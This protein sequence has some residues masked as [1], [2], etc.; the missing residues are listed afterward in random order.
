MF[1]PRRGALRPR[2]PC[3]SAARRPQLPS[4]VLHLV[5]IADSIVCFCFC[6]CFFKLLVYVEPCLVRTGSPH[7]AEEHRTLL[8]LQEGESLCEKCWQEFG[9]MQITQLSS[10]PPLLRCVRVRRYKM[11]G[12][13]VENGGK[14]HLC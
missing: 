1:D 8:P 13:R 7:S 4:S 2:L 3:G 6:F 9:T 12:L 10:V 5:P 11:R 14:M